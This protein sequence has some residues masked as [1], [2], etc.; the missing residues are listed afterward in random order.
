MS[1]PE[2]HVEG[3]TLL[4]VVLKAGAKRVAVGVDALL[5]ER[6][7]II[8][9]LD[10]P[11]AHVRSL[12][13]GILLEDGSVALVLN[14][15]ASSRATS[16]RTRPRRS[17]SSRPAPR[18][19]T[20]TVLVVDDSFTTRTL[21]KSI[22]EAH[23]YQVRIAMDGLEA[24]D[25]LRAE[26]VDLV[27]TDVQMPRM[28]GLALLQAM[29]KDPRLAGLPVILV[30]SMDRREDQERGLALGADAYIV[31][32]KFDHQDLLNTIQQILD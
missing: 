1:D 27:I 9:D 10:G 18:S 29:K 22:L 30:T 5:A 32:R 12:A 7:A 16:R 19:K 17:R 26:K 15:R 4:V 11:A 25:R 20:P 24:L 2:F 28:D 3:D 14:P 23:G 13:G 31:K 6:D 21:E 8:K